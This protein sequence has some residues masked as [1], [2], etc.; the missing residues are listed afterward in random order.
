MPSI[1]CSIIDKMCAQ[2]IYKLICIRT[3]LTEQLNEFVYLIENAYNTKIL[4]HFYL[5][6]VVTLTISLTLLLIG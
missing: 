3:C 1:P 2:I 4:M 6:D 5:T